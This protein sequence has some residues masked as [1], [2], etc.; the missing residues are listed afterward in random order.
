MHVRRW[1]WRRLRHVCSACGCRWRDE[2]RR[3]LGAP[4]EPG[5]SLGAWRDSD[6]EALRRANAMTPVLA[7]PL[8]TRGQRHR[9]SAD[10]S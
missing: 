1:S 2:R 9:A 5:R 10:A 4:V 7:L 6:A 3:C 8:L